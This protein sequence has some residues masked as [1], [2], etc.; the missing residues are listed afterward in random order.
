MNT[1]YF[2]CV[3][4]NREYASLSVLYVS[5]ITY[6]VIQTHVATIIK[7]ADKRLNIVITHSSGLYFMLVT[8]EY[9]IIQ[10]GHY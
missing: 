9:S 10:S 8:R 7:M 4:P 1:L 5:I 6:K 2:T 3:N